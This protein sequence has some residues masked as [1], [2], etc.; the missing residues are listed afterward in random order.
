MDAP[1]GRGSDAALTGCVACQKVPDTATGTPPVTPWMGIAKAA[2]GVPGS[3]NIAFPVPARPDGVPDA[4]FITYAAGLDDAT[5]GAGLPTGTM[6]L[7]GDD[8]GETA[9]LTSVALIA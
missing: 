6:M 3:V 4:G 1:V 2:L 7:A 9:P 8:V 5:V